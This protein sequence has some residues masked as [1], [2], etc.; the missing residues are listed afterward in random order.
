MLDLLKKEANVTLTENLAVSH[1]TSFSDCL[2]LFA[3]IGALRN[4]PDEDVIVRFNRAFAENPPQ[5]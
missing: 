5:I 2:D 4:A 3:T 1:A